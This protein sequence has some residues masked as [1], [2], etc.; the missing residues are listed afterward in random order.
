MQTRWC[1]RILIGTRSLPVIGCCSHN[2]AI[3]GPC[4]AILFPVNRVSVKVLRRIIVDVWLRASIIVSGDAFSKVIRLNFALRRIEIASTPFPIDLVK[5]VR[6]HHSTTDNALSRC[7]LHG[8]FNLAEEH[9]EACPDVRRIVSLREGELRAISAIFDC[10]L[11]CKCPIRWQGGL[12]C[13]VDFI[14]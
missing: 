6:H 9:V 13:E 4:Q 10:C 14:S 2:I 3:D 7:C 1:L 11:I 5:I 8:N 12:F